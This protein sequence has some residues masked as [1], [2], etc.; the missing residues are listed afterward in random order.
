MVGETLT[1]PAKGMSIL[2]EVAMSGEIVTS[3]VVEKDHDLTVAETD[4]V[5]TTS[6]EDMDEMKGF[7]NE[8]L[9]FMTETGLEQLVG[10]ES[11]N[12]EEILC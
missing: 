11:V 5:M 10:D 2:Q 6:E 7:K 4:C 12:V 8:K 9:Q 1:S 3:G